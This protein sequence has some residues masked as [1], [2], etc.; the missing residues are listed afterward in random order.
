VAEVNLNKEILYKQSEKFVNDSLY[1]YINKD[2]ALSPQCANMK[3][4][5]AP[6]FAFGDPAD[7]LF[8][9]YK[10]SKIIGEHF[11]RPLEWLANAKTVISFFLP[12]TDVIKSANS[13]DFKWPA[14]EWLHGRYE[15]QILVNE[16]SLF[17]QNKLIRAGYDSVAPSSDQRFMLTYNENNTTYKANWSERHVA[18]VCGLGTFGLSKGIITR[19]GTCGRLGSILTESDFLKNSRP[20]SDVFEYCTMCSACI[21]NCPPNAISLENGK[22]SKLCSKFLDDIRKKCTPR[23][24]CG[25]CQV[26]VPCMSEIPSK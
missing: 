2:M 25:K 8:I 10:S 9:K 1:N 13:T 26:N 7:D 23:Y 18:Y 16:L 6:L 19:K 11:L 22:D 4:F 15:G 14:D 24:G 21:P 12:Y 3:I 5:D 17:I 20:Y